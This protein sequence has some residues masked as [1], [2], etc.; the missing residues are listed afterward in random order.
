M[1]TQRHFIEPFQYG[2]LKKTE[3]VGERVYEIKSNFMY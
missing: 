3:Y 1:K 2:Y